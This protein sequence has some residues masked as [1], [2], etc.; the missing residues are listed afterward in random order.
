MGLTADPTP[1]Q[2]A[3]SL[4]AEIIAV[5]GD[6]LSEI[7]CI[8]SERMARTGLSMTHWHVLMLLARHGEMS[9]SRLA[10]AQQISLSNA[11]GLV[12][13]LVERGLVERVGVPDDRRVVLV[14]VSPQGE[15]QLAEVDLLREELIRRVIGQLDAAQLKRL[16]T[17]LHDVRDAFGRVLTDV[18]DPSLREHLNSY[19]HAARRGAEPAPA[20]DRN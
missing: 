20:A 9:M 12:D 2:E 19:A 5:I 8:G 11:T 1:T 18:P 3:D 17:A 16:R 4:V 14:R 6:A 15:R 7:K 10:E 13:R